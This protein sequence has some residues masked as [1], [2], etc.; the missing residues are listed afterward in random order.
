MG[1]LL[2][3]DTPDTPGYPVCILRG[4]HGGGY[5]YSTWVFSWR[6]KYPESLNNLVVFRDL[7]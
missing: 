6:K 3:K 5:L 1:E 7:S 4:N 2:V